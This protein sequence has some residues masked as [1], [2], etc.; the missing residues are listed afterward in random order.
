MVSSEASS[1]V[2]GGNLVELPKPGEPVEVPYVSEA[3]IILPFHS[4]QEEGQERER[5]G[6]TSV[7]LHAVD[8]VF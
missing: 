2:A 6:Y 1:L 3:E 8:S 7:N 4:R 5:D